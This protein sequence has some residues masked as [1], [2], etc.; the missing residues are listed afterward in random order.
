MIDP[1]LDDAPTTGE[2]SE[3]TLRSFAAL[4]FGVFGALFCLSWYRHSGEATLAGWISLGVA[5]LVGVPGLIKPSLVRPVFLAAI[6]ATHPIGRVMNVLLLGGLYY[7]LVTPLA[8]VFRLAGR[9][10]LRRQR[11][12]G[13]TYWIAK[14][15]VRDVSRYLRQYQRQ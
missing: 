11:P 2:V 4:C 3:R 9:D 1:P 8:L 6:T 12:S 15:Q 7:G 13:T 5:V 14:D 10:V